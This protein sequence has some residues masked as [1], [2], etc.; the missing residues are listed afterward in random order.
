MQ[1]QNYVME[2]P[3][4]SLTWTE[5][6]SISA[7]VGIRLLIILITMFHANLK[8]YYWHLIMIRDQFQSIQVCSKIYSRL[9][10]IDIKCSIPS[11]KQVYL[12]ISTEMA[13]LV[14]KKMQQ[15]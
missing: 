14:M 10:M 8:F 6:K 2:I 15:R 11:A 4:K 7:K 1:T 5:K 13:K 9:E 3:I 12:F